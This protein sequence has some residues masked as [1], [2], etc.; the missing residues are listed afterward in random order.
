MQCQVQGNHGVIIKMKIVASVVVVSGEEMSF[1]ENLITHYVVQ[2]LL[3]C[4]RGLKLPDILNL[5]ALVQLLE[6]II[7]LEGA[8]SCIEHNIL[9]PAV[10]RRPMSRE[11]GDR[12]LPIAGLAIADRSGRCGDN[13]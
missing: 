3:S 11:A 12:R 6:I 8:G 2:R 1:G 4:I 10:T 7:D 9:N 5:V 13:I